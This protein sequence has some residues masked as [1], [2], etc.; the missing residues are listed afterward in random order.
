LRPARKILRSV[1]FV[2]E[3]ARRAK[4]MF[5]GGGTRGKVASAR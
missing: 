5:E 4:S 2:V 1:Q 3:E